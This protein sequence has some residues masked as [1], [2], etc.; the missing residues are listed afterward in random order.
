MKLFAG[1]FVALVTPFK[2]G[3]LDEKKLQDLVEFHVANKTAGIVPCG[4]T[5]ESATLNHQ[6]HARVVELVVKQ[7][8]GRLL[9][10][11]GSGSNST[12]E[13]LHLTRHA[14]QCGADGALVIVPY[15]NKPTQEGM[16]EHFSAI[17]SNVKIPLCVYNI[18]G[19]TGVNMLPSTLE[20]LVDKNKNIIA[21]KESSGNLEQVS[22]VARRL[23]G[24]PKFSLLSGDD[25]L[26][27]P[28]LSVG[29]C[30]VIS[31][32]A[33]LAPKDTV[34]LCAA[35]AQGKIA[36]AQKLHLKML[37]L[38]KALFVETNPAPVKTAMELLGLCTSEM[39]LP[40]CAI[41]SE[42]KKLLLQELKNYGLKK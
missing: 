6:E 32:L 10:M 20:R 29:G 8:R 26:T 5:G 14:Q 1:S 34:A 15:Y 28:I 16:F 36:Q 18:P 25:A 11:A 22:E 33:N 13:A 30:G 37:P 24:H 41:S 23:Q 31:V 27:L 3:V 39:R 4:T 7:A 9:V 17:A 19:R 21:V 40:M 2:A 38:I 12:T 35:F 42:S